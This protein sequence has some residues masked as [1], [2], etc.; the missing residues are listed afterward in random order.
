[1]EAP[2][3]NPAARP[4]VALQLIIGSALLIGLLSCDSIRSN[5]ISEPASPTAA[6]AK[7]S[8][9]STLTDTNSAG[10]YGVIPEYC[11]PLV[12][13][14]RNSKICRI[15]DVADRPP[16]SPP[17]PPVP[18][19]PQAPGVSRSWCT[20]HPLGP[21]L[22]SPPVING[23]QCWGA[24]YPV[25]Q[26]WFD[27]HNKRLCRWS[28]Y[29]P[30]QRLIVDCGPHGMRSETVRLPPSAVPLAE[31][32]PPFARDIAQKIAEGSVKP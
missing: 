26:T 1:M 15:V 28:W 9:A 19:I 30:T 14:P 32:L 17:I 8:G 12:Y 6:L 18:S 11:A 5:A 13:S 22:L 25:P 10:A 21:P 4:P 7:P 27:A 20:T 31:R 23:V 2:E 24:D 29:P 16:A 3:P